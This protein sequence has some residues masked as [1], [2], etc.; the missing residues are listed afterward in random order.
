MSTWPPHPIR[1]ASLIGRVVVDG[2]GEEIGKIDD[3]VLNGSDGVEALVS[4]G[5]ALVAT[6]NYTVVPL[7]ELQIEEGRPVSLAKPIEEYPKA[8]AA[9]AL[10][11]TSAES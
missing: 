5:G 4:V 9:E 10:V 8:N 6:L 7:Q 1:A 11:T 3:L 2:D